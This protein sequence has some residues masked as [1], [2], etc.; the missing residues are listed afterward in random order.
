MISFISQGSPDFDI[1]IQK[2]NNSDRQQLL[3]LK[4]DSKLGDGVDVVYI[5]SLID[6]S[7]NYPNKLGNVIYIGEAGREKKTGTRFSQHI[8]TEEFK[9]GDT[10]TNYTLS[11][12]YW[13][14]KK[15][16]LK[17]YILGSK[18]NSKARKSVESQLFQ[19]HLK[20]FGA[21]PIGQGAS[22]ESYRVSLINEIE[23]SDVLKNIIPSN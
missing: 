11:R 14:G 4:S 21:H 1:N 23:I 9:G 18:N 3:N 22:G 15:I 5:Y 20:V 10:G 19:H 17:I 8:C 12:Y 2:G 6:E 13:I 7:I 16:N